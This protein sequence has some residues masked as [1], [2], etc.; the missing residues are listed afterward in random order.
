MKKTSHVR[1][2]PAELAFLLSALILLA[3][4]VFVA[5]FPRSIG[6]FVSV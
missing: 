5:Y 4:C 3:S 6:L 1:D 2:V